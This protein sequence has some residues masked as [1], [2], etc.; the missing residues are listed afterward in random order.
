MSYDRGV[1]D[2]V[3]LTT[4]QRAIT[5]AGVLATSLILT[6][7]VHQRGGDELI[8]CETGECAVGSGASWI[9]TG[10][11]LVA[12]WVVTGAF[13]RARWLHQRGRLGPF[14]K[15][16]VP[17][18]EEIVEIISVLVVAY[19][20]YRLIRGGWTF[21]IIESGRP[22]EFL[23]GHLGR[24]SGLPLVPTRTT[25]F[26]FGALV[27]SPFAFAFGAMAGREWYGWRRRREHGPDVGLPDDESGVNPALPAGD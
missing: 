2:P 7:I 26:L 12:P 21:P 27:S 17:D 8:R 11:T 13:L 24:E 4:Q 16:L 19:L 10:I 18:I 23:E 9:W 20:G 5:A 14:S 1:N 15:R 3:P 6:A 22:N 25:W